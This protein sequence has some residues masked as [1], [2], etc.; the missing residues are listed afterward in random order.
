MKYK[1]YGGLGELCMDV[2]RGESGGGGIVEQLFL[3]FNQQIHTTIPENDM[4]SVYV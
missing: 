4:L 3:L 2:Q 1:I